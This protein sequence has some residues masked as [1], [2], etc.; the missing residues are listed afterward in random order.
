MSDKLKHYCLYLDESG[1]F[2]E[3]RADEKAPPSLIGGVFGEASA[4]SRKKARALLRQMAEDPAFLA[5]SGGAPLTVIHCTELPEEVKVPAR[6]QVIQWCA[7]QGLH[8]VFFRSR[9]KLKIIDSTQTYLNLLAEGLAQF[10]AWLS[11]RGGAK[12]TVCIGRRV[13]VAACEKNPRLGKQAI[14]ESE[15]RNIIEARIAIT[16]AKYLFD[17][18][19]LVSH[20]SVFDSDK[21]NELLVLSDYICS[22]RYTLDYP[23]GP[24]REAY[25]QP[26]E[27]GR[28][29]REVL[30]ELFASRSETFGFLGDRLLEDVRRDLSRRH[31]GSALYLALTRGK[32][33]R[34]LERELGDALAPP[35]F[36][37]QNQRT[38]INVFF[39]L[40]GGL[41]SAPDCSGDAAKLLEAFLDLLDRLPLGQE[42]LRTF[43]RVNARLYL[44]AAY[45]HLGR[46]GLAK[47]QLDSCEEELPELLRRPENLPLYF[48]LRNRQAVV[49]Q[50]CFRYDKAVELLNEALAVAALQQEGQANLFE[51]LGCDTQCRPSEQQ[52]KLLGSL[53]LSYQYMLPA[54]PEMTDKARDAAHRAVEAMQLP[55]DKRRHAM[56]LAEIELCAGRLDEAYRQFCAGLDCP[57]DHMSEALEQCGSTYDWYHAIRLAD[58]LCRGDQA[59]RAL[60][61]ELFALLHS[62]FESVFTQKYP[63]HSAARRMGALCLK[64]GKT[65]LAQAYFQKCEALCVGEK[66]DVLYGIGLACL[67]ER[68]LADLRNGKRADTLAA[69]FRDRC[70]RGEKRAQIPELREFFAGLARE[71]ETCTDPRQ[72]YQSVCDRVGH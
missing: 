44:S 37:D 32:P 54:H 1:G 8:F 5:A 33:G 63:A 48:I 47:E 4:C 69:R 42:D 19:S 61:Q 36:D 49:W 59:Q 26:A 66:E 28:T 13:D 10:M 31:W 56:T 51:L 39:S 23:E 53:A 70:A 11:Y 14:P 2:E 7:E 46:A 27:D 15:Y 6:M 55:R 16:R 41:L 71:S 40:V 50:D 57:I 21:A 35:H 45:S 65:K 9:V 17:T 43:C 3:D 12:L 20:E 18:D 25:K 58:G 24:T 62:R 52:A 64:L 67:A 60:A 29:R 22:C 38:Q 30:E 34:S 72:F 68:I